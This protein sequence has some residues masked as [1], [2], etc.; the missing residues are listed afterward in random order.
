MVPSRAAAGTM[1]PGG[2]RTG[3]A[4]EG[5]TGAGTAGEVPHPGR[6]EQW[7]QGPGPGS[8]LPRP[9]LRLPAGTASLL[10]V[11][12]DAQEMEGL[13]RLKPFGCRG[14]APRMKCPRPQGVWQQGVQV[15]VC[16]LCLTPHQ[17]AREAATRARPG[18][19]ES[20]GPR[21]PGAMTLPK[22]SA[23][24]KN[25]SP[26]SEGDPD[27]GQ[28]YPCGRLYPPSGRL[29]PCGLGSWCHLKAGGRPHSPAWRD[30]L[31]C[32]S[33]QTSFCV[34]IEVTAGSEAP[35]SACRLC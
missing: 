6:N 30:R 13:H 23:S 20:K 14:P 21:L 8:P 33:L 19:A 2:K 16:A 15:R 25:R 28:Q 29:Y 18:P 26:C 22:A 12:S 7:G 9:A 32:V 11:T 17:P 10:G 3:W 5:R 4:S 34:F 35:H 24:Y 1:A 31:Q 27:A